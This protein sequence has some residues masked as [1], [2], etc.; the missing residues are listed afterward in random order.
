MILITNLLFLAAA[1]ATGARK[2][3]QKYY[4]VMLFVS[5][6]NLLYNFLCY[7]YMIWAFHP[8]FLLSHKTADLLNTFILLPSAV[9]LYLHFY[10]AAAL[11]KRIYYFIWVAGFS[12]IEF[13]WH[14]FGRIAY[15]HGW[16]IYWSIAF[17]FTMFG[18]IRL[19]H[20]RRKAGLLVSLISVVFLVIYYRV[21][22]TGK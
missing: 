18:T 12:T 8:D 7:D 19:L 11:S 15:E 5:L 22:L 17:Y 1:L 6:C 13:I 2:E 10:P 9:L 3:W 4:D 20:T 16:N 21:P 14:A